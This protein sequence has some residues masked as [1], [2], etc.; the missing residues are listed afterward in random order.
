MKWFNGVGIKGSFI[1]DNTIVIIPQSPLVTVYFGFLIQSKRLFYSLSTFLQELG[2]TLA[3]IQMNPG[4]S[5][6]E[7]TV[8]LYT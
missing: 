5:F 3:L 4:S 1:W 8:I 7:E 2:K 6:S